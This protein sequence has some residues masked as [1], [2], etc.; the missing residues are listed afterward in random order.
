MKKNFRFLKSLALTGMLVTTML[1]T[2][3][4]AD[5]ENKDVKT[6]LIGIYNKLVTDTERVIPFILANREDFVS[7]KDIQ[8]SDEFKNETVMFDREIKE[9]TKLHTGDTFKANGTT[10]TIL[11]YGDVNQDGDV[12]VFDAVTIQEN[13][14]ESSLKEIQE[15]A[16]NVVITDESEMDVFDAVAIQKYVGGATNTIIDKM[17]ED[18]K[19]PSLGEKN[20]L[21]K[22]KSYLAVMPFSKNGLIEQ[23]EYEGFTKQEA[24]YG[25]DNCKADWNE[26]AIKKAKNYIGIM[27][28]SRKGLIEQ[29]EYEGFTRQEAIYGVDN[30]KA[31][32]N[33]QAV[34]KA[35]SYIEIM[36]FSRKDLIEQLE[37]EGFTKEEAEYG[38]TSI[39]Y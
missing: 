15:I 35:K 31:D 11:I 25:V 14:F 17:P 8:E 9:D 10:Y 20:A 21:D 38:V 7:K 22:A 2:V 12:D 4:Y 27:S 24:M 28:F 1:G 34:R 16:A 18:K 32:W 19:K 33:E 30:C 5:T 6:E 37:Y 36:S 39:G 23:L 29:L 3:V 26:Q 13:V